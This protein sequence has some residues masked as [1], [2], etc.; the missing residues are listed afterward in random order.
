MRDRNHFFHQG[1][2]NRSHKRR[3][4]SMAHYIANENP[5]FRIR[6]RRDMEEVTSNRRSRDVAAVKMKGAL[7]MRGF[8]RESGI[9]LR[10]EGLLYFAGHMEIILHLRITLA[11]LCI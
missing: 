6:N 11:D 5:R 4:H 1:P 8:A 3:T 7:R 10:K 2:L 9:L